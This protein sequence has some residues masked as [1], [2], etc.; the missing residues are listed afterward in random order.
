MKSK[1]FSEGNTYRLVNQGNLWYFPR[2]LSIGM[3]VLLLGLLLFQPR[4]PVNADDSVQG[5]C[6]DSDQGNKYYR[7]GKVIEFLGPPL[8]D[9]CLNEETLIEYACSGSGEAVSEEYLC[10]NG[11]A[12]GACVGPNILVI[13]WDGAQ[14]DHLKQCFNRELGECPN[15]LP[16]LA[17]LSGG[18]LFQSTV[19]NG[20]TNTKPGWAQMLTGYNTDV[21]RVFESRNYYPIPE[22]YTV[23]E[24][25]EH[26]F[27]E[28]KVRSIF[29]SGKGVQ[30]GGEE[31]EVWYLTRN[32]L[33]QFES[34]LY[35][36]WK[37]GNKALA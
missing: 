5:E 10:P 9:Q 28:D 30:T 8:Y 18:R 36:N 2:L 25:V 33:D 27:G 21:I 6:M 7:S 13:G 4:T 23:F 12:N 37:I 15:G 35:P 29:I 31:G 11:C 24:K 20:P 22:G 1:I 26:H 19:T 17:K 3:G 32:H 14:W 16:N 34:Q